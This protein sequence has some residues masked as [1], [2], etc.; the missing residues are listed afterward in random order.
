MVL[1]WHVGDV[2]R[3]LREARHMSQ[4]QFGVHVGKV[5]GRKK[6]DKSTVGRLESGG[7][8]AVKTDTLK[9]AA[10]ALDLT[11]VD[12]YALV[13]KRTQIAERPPGRSTP[14]GSNR[15]KPFRAAASDRPQKTPRPR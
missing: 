10:R 12:L 2:V 8:D 9:R 14:S 13:P 5:D 4:T 7:E 15:E 3:K 11:V 1:I 6:M